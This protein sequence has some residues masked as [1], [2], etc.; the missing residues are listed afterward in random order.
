LILS[1]SCWCYECHVNMIIFDVRL[2]N[3]DQLE[4]HFC[5]TTCHD[6]RW[7][8]WQTDITF[9]VFGALMFKIAFIHHNVLCTS[10]MP[11]LV[12][13]GNPM[14]KCQI[15]YSFYKELRSG[16]TSTAI[17]NL[18]RSTSYWSRLSLKLSSLNGILTNLYKTWMQIKSYSLPL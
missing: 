3:G 5:K 15:L 13:T 6:S 14:S 16:D 10:W 8:F 4:A 1:N 9:L 2:V 18:A 7:L 12:M 17:E 11:C